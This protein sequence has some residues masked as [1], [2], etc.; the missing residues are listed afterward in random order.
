LGILA[1]FNRKGETMKLKIALLAIAGLLLFVGVA[2]ASGWYVS[3]GKA[4]NTAKAYA[5]QECERDSE[6]IAWGAGRCTRRSSSRFDCLVANFYPGVAAGEEIECQWIAHVGVSSGGFIQ[7]RSAG[8]P[9][10]Y[11][12]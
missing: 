5:K 6:C 2:E 12:V 8:R 4:R 10:C 9:S 3:Y 7:V 1:I 11:A